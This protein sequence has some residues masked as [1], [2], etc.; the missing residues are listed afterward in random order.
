MSLVFTPADNG[1]P[2]APVTW[3]A[4]P[5]GAPVAVSG[6]ATIPCDWQPTSLPNQAKGVFKC[7]IPSHLPAAFDELFVDGLRQVRAR[8]PNGDPLIPHSGYDWFLTSTILFPTCCERLGSCLVHTQIWWHHCTRR[9]TP[10][11]QAKAAGSFPNT[12][13]P[14]CGSKGNVQVVS[15]STGKHVSTGCVP[16]MPA[17][18]SASVSVVDID[19]PRG[20]TT[21]AIAYANSS[22]FNDT[23][24]LP[25]W[26]T[27]STS[28][29]LVPQSWSQRGWTAQDVE[30][31][32]AVV[33]MMH[34]QAWGSWVFAVDSFDSS[35]G[36]LKFGSGGNQ[37]AR[38]SN[39]VGDMYIENILAEL[40]D[41]SEWFVDSASRELYFLPKAAPNG[42]AAR[43]DN[44]TVVEV[45][46]LPRVIQ[47]RGSSANPVE[48]ISMVGFNVSRAAPTYL[49]SYEAPSGGDWA[50]HRGGAVF[51]DG[52]QYLQLERL[53][54]DQV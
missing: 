4:Y 13:V 39:S 27:T 44:R 1:A 32:P 49:D 53:Y 5:P 51:I 36:S 9:Y 37:E 11:A 21:T 40:D 29:I 14:A 34:P 52:A 45:P 43:L 7:T 47:F 3:Q 19:G 50:I 20:V 12:A 38:G 25:M 35:S 18:W 10:G 28:Q 46:F 42:Q 54:F 6:G 24:N 48:Y 33:K 16:G 2:G 22:R 23:F 17:D 26:A 31:G 8:F 30:T 15:Q 41:A